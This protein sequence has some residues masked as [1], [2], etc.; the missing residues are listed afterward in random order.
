MAFT[1]FVNSFALSSSDVSI[2]LITGS[3]FISDANSPPQN[4]G[5]QAAYVGFEICNTSGGT[6]S[7]LAANMAVSGVGFALAGN[8]AADQSIGTLAA[9][10]CKVLYWYASYPYLTKGVNGSFDLT[11]TDDQPGSVAHNEMIITRSSQSANSGGKVNSVTLGPGVSAGQTFYFDA[12]YS[13]GNTQVG[14]EFIFQ[15]AGTLG[16]N[17][18]CFQLIA[19]EVTASDVDAVDVGMTDSLYTIAD[20]G[21]NQGGTNH[22]V[23]VRYTFKALCINATTNAKPYSGQTSGG[24]NFKYSGNFDDAGYPTLNIPPTGNGIRILK[25]ASPETIPTTP[26]QVTYTIR[27]Y[28]DSSQA[29]TVDELLDVLPTGFTFNM[30]SGSSGVDGT[31]SSSLP[32]N[33]DGDTIKFV[34]GVNMGGGITS[35]TIPGGDSL[36][37]IYTVDIS[38]VITSGSHSNSVSAVIGND[39]TPPTTAI[40]TIGG[41]M[42]PPVLD[43]PGGLTADCSAPA[44]YVDLSAFQAA[45]GTATDETA[46]DAGSFIHVGDV[47]DGMTCPETITRTY[48]IADAAGNTNTCTQI[49]TID[50]DTDPMISCPSPITMDNDA[51][52]CSAVVT[53]TAPTGTDNC[54]GPSTALTAG[55]ASGTAFPVG[56]TT[57][58][59]TVTDACGNTASCSF[60]VTVNDTEPPTATN[61]GNTS[62]NNDAGQC[63]AVVNYGAITTSDNCAGSS[64]SQTVGQA[65]GTLFPIGTTTNTF[66]ITDAAG[67]TSTI[68]FDVTVT[69]NEA[70]TIN[71]PADI[72]VNIPSGMTTGVANY[73]TPTTSDNCPGEALNQTAGM[74]SGASFTL[75]TT[76][77]TFEVTDASG[78]T[79]T[80]SFDVTVQVEG[81][82]NCPTAATTQCSI[83]DVPAFADFAAFMAAG[84]AASDPDGINAASFMQLGADVSDGMTC[85]ETVTRTYQIADNLGNTTTCTHSIVIDDDTDPMITCP[86]P[87]TMGNDAGLCSAVITYTA[88]TGTDNCAGPSTA[89]TAG[90]ASGTAF[91][92]GTTTNT[93]TVTDACGNTASCSF[94]VTVNDT[95]PPT[96]NN[97]GNTSVNN[98]AGQCGAVVNYATIT[99]SD[100]ST[101]ALG[102]KVL[103][104]RD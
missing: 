5:P 4:Q 10:E 89:Q 48:Q 53:Y 8:Q 77:N 101:F 59:Y 11:L 25:S 95:E 20:P 90:Q 28:N 63:G 99:A 32:G 30:L 98:D 19:T 103:K 97:P 9:G 34:G 82:I 57:N 1:P 73:A 14:D 35:Y 58:T 81:V 2:N 67:N 7:G 76:T 91:T 70:P 88:P 47:S 33:G 27:I 102:S 60:D 6:L 50:D 52:L 42:T 79:M 39:T 100:N 84:G 43:C 64:A 75:G 46:L 16:F 86:S 45:G 94:D 38:G 74:A 29:S 3:F 44:A 49:I 23:T 41:D 56:T 69:D 18:E 36:K 15:P 78:N 31:N 13:F 37:L 22:E 21:D 51:G 80:C 40:V 92:V 26:A 66:E 62:V 96:A 68:S 93:F 85:P 17:A 87:I 72:T 61:P 71:C 65:S 54:A 104:M 24:G 83:G 55:Q 12:I